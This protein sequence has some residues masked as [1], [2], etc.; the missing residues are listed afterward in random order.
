MSD[1]ELL[2]Y[3]ALIHNLNDAV[4]VEDENRKIIVTNQ[5]FC[6][7]FNVPAPP[8]ALLGSDCSN[9]AEQSKHLFKDPDAFLHSVARSLANRR[10]V[11]NEYFELQNGTSVERD[12]IPIFDGEKHKGHLWVYKNLTH[13]YQVERQLHQ[14]HHQ[15]IAS[16]SHDLRQPSQALSLFIS[17]L[18]D[19]D[20]EPDRLKLMALLKKSSSTLNELLN[21]L[22]DVSNLN[23]NATQADIQ[24]CDLGDIFQ[25]VSSNFSRKAALKNIELHCFQPQNSEESFWVRTDQVLLERLLSN[26][27]DNAI[28]YTESGSVQIH[29][30]CADETGKQIRVSVK[31]TGVGI[32]SHELDAI[33]KPF[34][35]VNSANNHGEAGFGLGLSIVQSLCE[36]LDINLAVESIVGEGTSFSF[37]LDKCAEPIQPQ[38]SEIS[39]SDSALTNKTILIIEDNKTV[40]EGLSLQL[41]L[42]GMQVVTASGLSE[43]SDLIGSATKVDIILSGLT[44]KNGDS[45]MHIIDALKNKPDFPTVP[46]IILSG[47]TASSCIDEVTRRGFSIL[48]KPVKPAHLRSAVQRELINL[49][50]G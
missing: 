5:A 49:N 9:S 20:K 11:K 16:A 48:L 35:Q 19:S 18:E 34:Y 8:E 6:D 2:R 43:A 13:R 22:L 32:H 36:K 14:E 1:N 31:D 30:T 21:N 27:V 45:G 39:A 24:R 10:T 38:P 4:L 25:S 47:D 50:S 42:W 29:A 7:L 15:F 28:K 41:S 3:K 40:L 12:Y 37:L 44:F 46:V 33:F 23:N 26:L 17:A